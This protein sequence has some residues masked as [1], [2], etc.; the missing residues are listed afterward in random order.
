ML[1]CE[2]FGGRLA[3]VMQTIASLFHLAK[4]KGIPKEQIRLPLSY[5]GEDFY[6][7]KEYVFIDNYP[8]FKNLEECFDYSIDLNQYEIYDI[9]GNWGTYYIR[10]DYRN[11]NICV[12]NHWFDFIYNTNIY[13]N[14]FYRKKLWD[15]IRCQYEH[16]LSYNNTIAIHVRRKDFLL[17]VNDREKYKEFKNRDILDINKIQTIIKN[18]PKSTNILI[19]SDDIVWCK[20]NIKNK[21]N[22]YFIEGN[23]PYKD[24]ILMSMCDEIVRTPGSTFGKMAISLRR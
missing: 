14:L 12:K 23:K 10:G 13:K 21:K 4:I 2:F 11:K 19:F 20:E 1:T 24:L 7:K 16:I 8:I 9:A 5:T 17:L 18:I 22:I 15:D 6:N 3:E